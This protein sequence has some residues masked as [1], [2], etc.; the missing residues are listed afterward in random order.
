MRPEEKPE[1]T[2]KRSPGVLFCILGVSVIALSCQASSSGSQASVPPSGRDASETWY[3]VAGP[4]ENFE[5]VIIEGEGSSLCKPHFL[6]LFRKTPDKNRVEVQFSYKCATPGQ[7]RIRVTLRASDASGA[8]LAEDAVDTEDIRVAELSQP[9]LHV[10]VEL[11][12]AEIT[13]ANFTI[14][15]DVAGR[16]NQLALRFDKNCQRPRSPDAGRGSVPGVRD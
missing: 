8:L 7:D 14:S 12:A 15:D 2:W 6:T 1:P 10:G 16:T 4:F 11:R 9:P 3:Q 5:P 13:V